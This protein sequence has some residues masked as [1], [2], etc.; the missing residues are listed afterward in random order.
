MPKHLAPKL[1]D[2]WHVE[3]STNKALL[4]LLE[5]G[6]GNLSVWEG[7]TI[8]V[9]KNSDIVD[10]RLRF[11]IATKWNLPFEV[12]VADKPGIMARLGANRTRRTLDENS[13]SVIKIFKEFEI[14]WKKRGVEVLKENFGFNH[15]SSFRII[16]YINSQLDPDSGPTPDYIRGFV[17]K[18]T[19]YF[20]D[21]TEKQAVQKA[22][23][24]VKKWAQ[25]DGVD[26]GTKYAQVIEA[27]MIVVPKE[28]RVA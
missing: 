17:Y 12:E 4:K 23:R 20:S 18:P 16:A 11:K 26:L 22:L 28:H 15:S 9:D 25:A 13:L 8:L 6:P 24:Q 3:E 19:V 7:A 1:G 27:G 2:L 10:G 21:N 5:F 14:D